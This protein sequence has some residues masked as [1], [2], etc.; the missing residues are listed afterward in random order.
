VAGL[1][2]VSHL[3]RQQRLGSTERLHLGL[4]S[5]AEHHGL[6]RGLGK[7]PTRCVGFCTTRRTVEI[8]NDFWRLDQATSSAEDRGKV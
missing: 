6:L 2:H 7:R 4:L 3:Q 1:L 5:D 8:V